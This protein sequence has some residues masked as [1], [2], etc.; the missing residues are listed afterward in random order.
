MHQHYDEKIR[1]DYRRSNRHPKV[2]DKYF[3]PDTK[4]ACWDK[5][6]IIAGRDPSRWRLD[7]FG[8]PVFYFLKFCSGQYCYDFD[9]IVPIEKGGQNNLDNCQL[10]QASLMSL[11]GKKDNTTFSEMRNSS[12]TKQLNDFEMDA[13]EN[14]VYG[15]IK[16]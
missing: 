13:L 9:H 6:K 1:K 4:T 12:A 8:N 14:A 7:A 2:V 15:D 10:L 3:S 11:K 16:R 5:S